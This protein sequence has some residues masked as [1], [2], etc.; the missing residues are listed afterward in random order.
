[1]IVTYDRQNIFKVEAIGLDLIKPFWI[2][3]TE[4][5]CKLDLYR[6]SRDKKFMNNNGLAYSK[7]E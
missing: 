1:M 4:P 2:T 7:C 3:F 5:F 6:V